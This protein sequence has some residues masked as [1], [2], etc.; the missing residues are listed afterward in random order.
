MATLDELL[1]IE[2]VVAAGEFGADGSVIDYK[3]K[4]DMSPEMAQ[5]TA[6]FCATVTMMF[7]TLANSYTQLSGMRWVPQ[8]GWA[9]SGGDWTVAIGGGGHKG[10]FVETARADFNRLFEA[11]VEADVTPSTELTGARPRPEPSSG[12]PGTEPVAEDASRS[13]T[14]DVPMAEEVPSGTPPQA[15]PG[16]VQRETSPEP[17]PTGTR[18]APPTGQQRPGQ[19]EREPQ[20]DKGLIDR[21][22]DALLGEEEPR[23]EGTDR[24]ERMI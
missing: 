19:T 5:M 6:Q 23:R 12:F 4:M 13:R 17:R 3:A 10:V 24:P 7:N 9:Y 1:G 22:R 15:P 20:E 18:E 8:Q 21:A 14:E 2:G 11:L 16:D